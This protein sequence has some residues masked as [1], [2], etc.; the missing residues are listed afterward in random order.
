MK[1]SEIKTMDQLEKARKQVR[2]K[3]GSKGDDV[4]ASFYDMKESYTPSHLMISGLKS[5]SSYIPVDQ[6]LLTTVRR[7]RRRLL[8]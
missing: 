5:F 7:L 4:R 3:I 6:L 8:K 2:K 1:Y